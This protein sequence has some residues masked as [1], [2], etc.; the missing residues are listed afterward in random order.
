MGV[1]FLRGLA[2]KAVDRLDKPKT[3]ERMEDDILLVSQTIIPQDV[4]QNVE[5]V[6]TDGI[7]E[8]IPEDALKRLLKV[9]D[10]KKI[11]GEI[12][13]RFGQGD[14]ENQQEMDIQVLHKRLGELENSSRYE[15]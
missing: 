9:S 3:Y 7:S 8:G 14:S 11:A 10:K 15:G 4:S 2:K 6:P 5:T 12:N 13:R 1:E